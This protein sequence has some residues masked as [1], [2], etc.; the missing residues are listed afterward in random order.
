MRTRLWGSLSV[1]LV[2]GLGVG[3]GGLASGETHFTTGEL[4]RLAG[5]D[6]ADWRREVEA[7]R[8]GGQASLDTLF[9]LRDAVAREAETASRRQ[10]KGDLPAR[11]AAR[12]E[13]IEKLI[14]EVGGQRY[15]TASR[16]FWHT[17]LGAAK[18]EAL[19]SGKPILSLRMMGQLTDEFSCAN[20]RFFRATLYSNAELA[21]YLRSHFVLHW[22][23][24][25]PVPKVTIDF[26]DGRK[27]ERTLTG[28]SIHYVLTSD[29]QTV[30]A[31]PGL[32]GAKKFRALL[33]TAEQL[34]LEVGEV[35]GVEARMQLLA[36]HHQAQA[37]RIAREW[38]A[39]IASVQPDSLL[40]QT[41]GAG[42]D[43]ARQGAEP[44]EAPAD[45]PPDAKRAA[46]RATSKMRVEMP[47]L[48]AID[49]TRLEAATDDRLWEAIAALH[50]EEARLDDGSLALIRSQNPTAAQAGALA[51][52]KR[53][54]EDPV[55]KMVRNLESSIA[56]D[57]VRNEY[58]L[59]R[60]IHEWFAGAAPTA[61]VESLNE[62]VY[63]ELFL[64]PSS[65]PWI[66]LAPPDTYT[67][68]EN[69]GVSTADLHEG[70][71]SGGQ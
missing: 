45:Q 2:L 69:N 62:R 48:T 52:T 34:A 47:I 10:Q 60:R 55:L 64:T 22:K 13:R 63:A 40:L 56:L 30:D 15:C 7:L 50:A 49:A 43:K 58:L 31:L 24:V 5:A 32:Y 6:P 26:G 3:L 71:S 41:A 57:G 65:D 53:V 37:D 68:L 8:A 12:L 23:S 59:H 20:S 54:V 1:L 19:R 35:S 42:D 29:G 21:D 11:H 38:L 14:D 17:D 4:D 39:D 66:G 28:N 16:L 9:Q 61:D 18:R 25:R 67:A 33:E 36:E 27:L 70:A 51:R 44:T 46:R